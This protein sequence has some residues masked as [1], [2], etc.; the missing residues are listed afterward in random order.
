L[1]NRFVIQHNSHHV[2]ALLPYST[3]AIIWL[4]CCHR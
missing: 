4:H 2:V 1:K 3:T